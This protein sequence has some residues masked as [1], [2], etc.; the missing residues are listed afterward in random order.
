VLK[1][2]GPEA[3]NWMDRRS[4]LAGA[5]A[6]FAGAMTG[7]KRMVGQSAD[8]QLTFVPLPDPLAK[9]NVIWDASA[10]GYRVDEYLMSGSGPTF[11]PI[12]DTEAGKVDRPNTAIEWGKRD[13]A[14]SANLPADFSPRPQTGTG[15][16]T[17]SV[18]VYRPANSKKFSG[19]V[20]IEAVHPGGTIEVFTVANRFFLN[21]GDAVVHIEVPGRFPSLKKYSEERYGKL[22]MSDRSLFWTSVSQLATLLKVGGVNS[23]LPLAAS[24]L[25]MTGYS[26]SADTV[27]TF[28]SYHHKLTRMPDGKPVFS[29]YLPL[30]HLM[31]VPPIDAVIVTSATQ[32]DMFG[33]TDGDTPETRAF[34]AKFNSDVPNARRR[35][36][37]IP[38]AFHAPFQPAEP[39]MAIPLRGAEAGN[40]AAC[41]AAQHWPAEALNEH[42]PNRAMM[43][44]CFHHASRWAVDGIAPPSAPLIE[45]DSDGVTVKDEDGNVKGGLRFP[46][47]AVPTETFISAARG[48]TKSCAS[49][50]YSLA[51]S[52]EKLV[53]RYGTRERYLA[54]YDAVA[55]K[56]VKDGFILPEGGAQLKS[57][58]RW[59]APVF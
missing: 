48:G 58:R 41:S 22:F 49:T 1:Q 33:A 44:A 2:S 7:T 20:I 9:C 23:P 59:L 15:K 54:H 36:F 17:T 6:A 55:D 28:L 12:S 19:N 3:Q 50:G 51:F 42:L 40:F 35:R 16:Y 21:R 53:S 39:G 37:E 34:R 8:G 27:Y 25:Y 10:F 29:G 32:S 57:D 24:H 56:L 11:A 52:R 18:V 14:Y 13:T 46:D 47:I 43:E 31:P 38:G 45:V 30:S 4:F 5:G 26:G